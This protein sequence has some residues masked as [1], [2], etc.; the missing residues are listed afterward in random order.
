MIIRL[1]HLLSFLFVFLFAARSQE[2]SVNNPLCIIDNIQLLESNKDPKCHATA[3]RLEDFM[4]GTPLS[5]Y[6]RDK[7]VDLQKKLVLFIW[8]KCT[9][10]ATAEKQD[11]ITNEL[12]ADVLDRIN[13]FGK[14]KSGEWFVKYGENA[15]LVESND[16][17]QYSSVAY[18]LR[19]MLSVEQDFLFNP[20][21]E[22][23]P[24]DKKA[25]N[26][27]KFY[28]DLMTLASLQ[29]AD[30]NV[31]KENRYI[32]EAEDFEL[33]WNT[34]MSSS[35]E[36]IFLTSTYPSASVDIPVDS[37]FI[38]LNAIIKQKIESYKAYNDISLPILLRNIQVYFA[39]H[40][41]PTEQA[42]SDEL[43]SYLIESLVY[44]TGKL[45]EDANLIAENESSPF[46]RARHINA[47]VPN[48]MPFELNSFEDVIYFPE[49]ENSI[50]IESYDLDAFR[51]SGLHWLILN[52][53][54]QDADK[55]KIKE[56]D[57]FAAEVIVEAV[58]QMALLVLRLSG[59]ESI[60]AGNRH[61]KTEDMQNAFNRIQDMI[62]A[63][64]TLNSKVKPQNSQS[65][66]SGADKSI[67]SRIFF[68]A[69][70]EAGIDFF[71]KSS[72]WLSR[73]IR[74]YVVK[75][76][77][78]LIR[79]AIPPAFGGSGVAADD[80]NNDGWQDIILLSGMGLH[81][82]L[83]NADGS[84]E[85]ITA[86]SGLNIWNEEKKSHSE[87]RQIIIADF[88]NDGWQ[89][90]F[91]SLVDDQHR[92]F[93][94]MNGFRFKDVSDIAQLGGEGKVGG[95]A[96]AL[97]YDKDGLLDIYIGYFGNYLNGELPTLSRNNQNGEPNKLFRNK[98]SFEFEE[99][100]HLYKD[101]IDF[102]WTQALGH[103]DINQDGWQDIIVGNDFGVNA[104]YI[105][106]KNGYFRNDSK[107]LR[108]DKP[109]YTMN[110]G[111]ADLNGDMFPDLYISNIVVMEKDEKYVNPAGETSM[112][113][114]PEKMKNIRTVEANDLFI[115]KTS[116]DGIE[117]YEQSRDIG[118][119]Y[120][121]TG[122]SWDADFFDFDND[123]DQDLYVLN[124]MNDFRVY[125][126]ENPYYNSPDGEAQDV[127][128]AQSNKER[129]SFFV[130]ENGK[131]NDKSDVIGGDLLSNSRSA[132]YL[133][134]DND[135]D[136]DVIVN[137]YH[138]RAILLENKVSNKN[139]WI[140]L[141]LK[142]SPEDNI[143]KDAIGSNI[144]VELADSGTKLWREI[145]STTGYLSVHPKQQHFGLGSEDT[146]NITIKWPDGKIQKFEN[147]KANASY[148]IEYGQN[149]SKSSR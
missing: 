52:Y 89:D 90:V 113:F 125:G 14:L 54:V 25:V 24:L 86:D 33:A 75:Q 93:K 8:D 51:D 55:T 9:K 38:T 36:K 88:D 144:I 122:W 142:G 130:N 109:S 96:T 76:D 105:N 40:K 13:V 46:L 19:A 87:P 32:I 64:T 137:N 56:P 2:P 57:P 31:R 135:G 94:N 53:T 72:D 99:K 28:L 22:L 100:I 63:S 7:R 71:H 134:F 115:S 133:D 129:N 69:T 18:A 143:N 61:I 110:V 112:N 123:T 78:N 77:E 49:L 120:S 39:R 68:D 11:T 44:F 4:Y 146:V 15:I 59:E 102:G 126:V 140:K 27:I 48:Y 145:T 139:H 66:I 23:K 124:G 138:D 132:S 5:P 16:L 147:I 58:A 121:S 85:N 60:A 106:Q 117:E 70:E 118:R 34:L 1:I 119:G 67:N 65:L 30:M 37:S 107:R 12:V 20:S 97:D 98:G 92:L 84:F 42:T 103:C 21:W 114:D 26:S 45:L 35:S 17:R 47:V 149:I 136:L 116:E 95:P 83:N 131:L 79:M 111:T 29:M 80:L 6:A 104:Y 81:Y 91:I 62:Y 41:W 148:R 128:Y 141:K 82:Y 108:T 3:S 101:D 73:L 43:R 127:V 74:S 10:I 50:M